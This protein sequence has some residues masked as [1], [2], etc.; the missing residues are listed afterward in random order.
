MLKAEIIGYIRWYVDLIVRNC[1][2]SFRICSHLY[3]GQ[4]ESLRHVF[5]SS[6]RCADPSVDV[7]IAKQRE[8]ETEAESSSYF[9][10]KSPLFAFGSLR[11]FVH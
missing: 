7:V 6:D 11:A 5:K 3:H 4:L 1:L 8:A 2:I 9:R 10:M